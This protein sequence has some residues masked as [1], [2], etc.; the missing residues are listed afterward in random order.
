M[1]QGLFSL[2]FKGLV[3]FPFTSK[4]FEQKLRL[5]NEPVTKC[6]VKCV[7]VFHLKLFLYTEGKTLQSD[8]WEIATTLILS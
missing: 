8:R 3:T 6:V 7:A 2:K 1:F 5:G 4:F